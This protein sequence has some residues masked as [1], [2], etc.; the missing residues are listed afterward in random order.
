MNAN[1]LTRAH[2]MIGDHKGGLA[3][4]TILGFLQA[5]VALGML[6]VLGLLTALFAS[7]GEAHCPRGLFN[8]LPT[9][10]QS[11]VTGVDQKDFVLDRTGLLPIVTANLSSK[12]PVHSRCAE[13]LEE[14]LG[15]VPTLRNNIGSLTTLL[16]AGLGLVLLH[17]ILTQIRR[18]K[19]AVL[20]AGVASNLRRL[21]H[22]QL[23]R[24]G[25]SSLATEGTGPAVN[26]LTREVTDVRDAL[27]QNYE[28]RARLPVLTLGL[29]LS[30]LAVDW[31]LTLFLGALGV[32]TWLVSRR[33]IQDAKLSHD[34]S[35]REASQHLPLIHE[36]MGMIRTVR[37]Y[38]MENVDKQRFD[39]HLEKFEEADIR[40]V[41]AD[42]VIFPTLW[43]L[44]GASIAL[45]I[46]L[47]GYRVVGVQQLAPAG[48]VV[49]I[50]ALIGLRPQIREWMSL[51]L[52]TRQA[53][54]SANGIF[55]YLD[56][57]P[58][59]QQ[60]GGARFLPPLR[61][62][63]VFEN[64]SLEST[65]GRLLLEGLSAVVPAGTRTAVMGLDEDAKHALVCL[66]PRLIDPKSGHVRV[67]GHDL[68]EMTLESVRAQVSTVLQTDLIFTDSVLVN[69]GLGD[70]GATLPRVI[71][72]AKVAH[73]HNF[74]QDL[75]DGYDTV[76]GPVGHYLTQDQH[77]RI[78]LARAY[79]H[80]P[81]IVIVEEPETP[82]DEDIKNLVDDTMNRIAQGR[83]LIILPHR[84]S[85]IRSCDQIIIVHNGRVE[86]TGNPRTLQSQSK[87][88]RHLQYVE[89]NQFATGE[90]EAGQMS[91]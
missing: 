32:L 18:G 6:V 82:L 30:A 13:A 91:A 36:D 84:L 88:F 3:L 74:I 11:Q 21:I 77:Y 75:P 79:L 51:R 64:V 61:D 25:Q 48:A 28:A 81:S 62:K 65:S 4:V 87:L 56:R 66:I 76:I 69:I 17:S 15:Q 26:L 85:T 63:I 5:L 44:Y 8:T 58:E 37:V 60:E 46:G 31:L 49:V 57:K 59:L 23:Y 33:L 71:E 16:A 9:W 54:R 7:Q 1:A 86:I 45:A 67:D 70:P 41:K 80:D 39:A 22:R 72:A 29:L 2:K 38:G 10:A 83:T 53:N 40:R 14:I 43:L 73:A 12:N 78:A 42:G 90:I 19:I 24:L 35:L 52:S 27:F 47:V 34:T 20:T 89:F 55:E 68:R 50:A